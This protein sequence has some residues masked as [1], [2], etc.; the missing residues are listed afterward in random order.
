[1]VKDVKEFLSRKNNYWWI[2]V[3]D[4][5]RREEDI[6]NDIPRDWWSVIITTRSNKWEGDYLVEDLDKL[7]REDAISLVFRNLRR[8]YR[9]ND[10]SSNKNIHHR[11]DYYDDIV[12]FMFNWDEDLNIEEKHKLVYK[13]IDSFKRDWWYILTCR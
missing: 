6:K 7:D 9:K 3:F 13:K 4:D 10:D 2:L 1:M 12:Q 8:R 11:W 5:V